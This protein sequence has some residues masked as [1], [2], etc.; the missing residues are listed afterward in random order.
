M[1]TVLHGSGLDL[2]EDSLEISFLS[3][4]QRFMVALNID[5]SRVGHDNCWSHSESRDVL[6]VDAFR[7]C[8]GSSSLILSVSL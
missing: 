2:C 8:R 5:F 3:S 4:E 6:D 1:Q 7:A